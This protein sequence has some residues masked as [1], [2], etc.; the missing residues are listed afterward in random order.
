MSGAGARAAVGGGEEESINGEKKDSFIACLTRSLAC[1]FTT[2]HTHYYHF[3]NGRPPAPDARSPPPTTTLAA[4]RHAERA[5]EG[6]GG[7]G[8][9]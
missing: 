6:A 5:G 7:R 2:L 9:D 3:H 1:N 8:Q 4:V